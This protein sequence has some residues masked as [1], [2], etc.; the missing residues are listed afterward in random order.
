MYNITHIFKI[1]S[2]KMLFCL[3]AYAFC[4][5]VSFFDEQLYDFGFEISLHHNLSVFSR[6]AYSAFAFQ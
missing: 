1:F 4:F 6:S 2:Y 5:R 3:T